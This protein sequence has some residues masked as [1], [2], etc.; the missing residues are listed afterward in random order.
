MRALDKQD[1]NWVLR[2]LPRAVVELM[3]ANGTR[4]ILSGGYIRSAVSGERAN[5]I[6][7]FCKTAEDAKL[8][9]ETLADGKKKV[10]E[11]GNA[12]SIRKV[13]GYFV[14]FIHRWTYDNPEEILESFD[15]TIACA[16]VW[17]E[18][19]DTLDGSSPW[20]SL[21]ED[22]FYSDLAAKRLVY[23]APKRNEDAGGSMLRVLKFYQRGFRIP[24]DS[25]GAVIARLVDGVEYKQVE[26][27]SGEDHSGSSI[28]GHTTEERWAKIITGLLRV[29]DPAV[30][31]EH[32]S[33]LPSAD[34]EKFVKELQDIRESE[35]AAKEGQ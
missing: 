31:P 3:Q 2:T 22:N 34:V 9:A 16:S 29:V 15:F 10:F 4:I 28:G 25:L 26:I 18:A 17:Y 13:G 20:H 35:A 30:D 21:V 5:D 33:H 11:T 24:L 23:R 1:L 14:Q 7:L 27:L 32:E 12:Y 6:D 19:P 8:F